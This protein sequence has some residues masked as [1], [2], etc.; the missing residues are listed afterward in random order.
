MKL[1]STWCFMKNLCPVGDLPSDC[2]SDHK[3]CGT[4]QYFEFDEHLYRAYG[5]MDYNCSKGYLENIENRFP[6]GVFC[7]EYEKKEVEEIGK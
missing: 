2:P 7:K 4:C 6:C 1:Y 3:C 5:G